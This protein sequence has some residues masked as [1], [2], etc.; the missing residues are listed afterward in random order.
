MQTRNTAISC[1]GILD[2]CCMGNCHMGAR[3]CDF[4]TEDSQDS[5]DSQT[6]GGSGPFTIPVFRAGSPLK[7]LRTCFRPTA[8]I[9]DFTAKVMISCISWLIFIVFPLLH[10][11][12]SYTSIWHKSS[13]YV[14]DMDN[15]IDRY[16]LPVCQGFQIPHSHGLHINISDLCHMRILAASAQAVGPGYIRFSAL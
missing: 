15:T 13:S 16:R 12:F 2:N 4:P 5:Q 14:N 10:C 9:A 1:Q 11:I 3:P 6:T 8:S 7:A